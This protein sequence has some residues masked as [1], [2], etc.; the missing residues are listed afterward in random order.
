MTKRFTLRFE[1]L[2]KYWDM[3]I[4][5]HQTD[6]PFDKSTY[7][8]HQT[9]FQDSKDEMEDLCQLM[10]KLNEENQHIKHTIRT[11]MENERTEIGKNTLRQLWEA[12]Q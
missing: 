1:K 7:D 6:E 11:M 12:I 8:F 10:N 2:G 9:S 4:V 3:G 5:D